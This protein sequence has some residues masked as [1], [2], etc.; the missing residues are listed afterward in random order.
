MV[1]PV[2]L[3]PRK[4]LLNKAVFDFILFVQHIFPGFL[5]SS[6]RITITMSSHNIHHN[7]LEQALSTGARIIVRTSRTLPEISTM[8]DQKRSV[9]TSYLTAELKHNSY[10]TAIPII[11]FFISGLVDAVAFNTWGCFVGMQTGKS[12]P[13]P[14]NKAADEFFLGNTVFLALGIAQQPVASHNQQWTK[15]LTAIGF[16]CLGCA[17]FNFIHRCPNLSEGPTSRK[18]W[19]LVVSWV[20]QC[21]FILIAALFTHYGVVSNQPAIGGKYSSG[22]SEEERAEVTK[23]SDHY[24]YVDLVA[25]ALL[26]FQSAAPVCLSRI[27]CMPE[28][29]TIAVSSIY[30][31]W[32]S[33][34][35]EMRKRWNASTTWKSFIVDRSDGGE[36]KQLQRASAIVA[37]FLGAVITGQCYKRNY[38]VTT[39][40]FVAASVKGMIAFSWCFWPRKLSKEERFCRC[41]TLVCS[42]CGSTE[43]KTGRS[44]DTTPSLSTRGDT[45]RVNETR[46]RTTMP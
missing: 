45:E 39:S 23:N 10:M 46:R 9:V 5:T 43:P 21:I 31:S 28:L 24:N 41:D 3:L 36:N 29:P 1:L 7:D 37:L 35:F 16:A 30:H 18:R 11:C 26:A 33:G 15:S 2:R 4:N 38:G 20:I 13:P 32:T 25:I 17:F 34:L 14:L 42:N 19:I 22:S 8:T 12:T 44:G 40:L 6:R 27:L